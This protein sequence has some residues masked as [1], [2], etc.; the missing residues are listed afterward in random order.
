MNSLL[1]GEKEKHW[2]VAKKMYECCGYY[3]NLKNPRTFNEKIQ[4]LNLNYFNPIEQACNDKID[5][6]EYI[7][8]KLGVGWTAKLLKIYD[9]ADDINLDELPN[10]FV[11]K[12]TLSGNDSGV[13]IVTDK[14]VLEIDRLKYE[15][16][17][18]LQEWSS[19]YY[20][21]LNRNSHRSVRL[22][23]EE[24]LGVTDQY[25]NDYK[26]LCFNGKFKLGYVIVRILGKKKVFYFDKNWSLLPIKHVASMADDS[27]FPPK[28]ENLEKMIEIAQKCA[29]DFPFVRVDFYNVDG[30]L[31][32]GEFTFNPRS[33]FGLFESK[34][35]D[36]KLGEMLD[37]S[38]VDE[39]YLTNDWAKAYIKSL[40]STDF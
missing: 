15:A 27:Y 4:W 10:Q 35:S 12:N 1:F 34:E 5:F 13:K 25:L 29:V 17:N 2:F 7:K 39:K 31:Y 33:G 14:S 30:K 21:S 19:G 9:S 26:F 22:F 20:A 16:N 11:L 3:P 8:E 36:L 18:M 38:Q 40:K 28:P 24:F 23:A 6:K 37:L 32:L